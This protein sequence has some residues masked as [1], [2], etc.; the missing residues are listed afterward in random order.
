MSLLQVLMLNA[1]ILWMV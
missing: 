1:E